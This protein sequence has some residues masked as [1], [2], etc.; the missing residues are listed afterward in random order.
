MKQVPLGMG[1]LNGWRVHLRDRI[2]AD[3]VGEAENLHDPELM[4]LDPAVGMTVSPIYFSIIHT[5]TGKHIGVAAAYN[6][7]G[8]EVEY[9]IRIWNRDFWDKGYGA[10]V[11]GLFCAWA[12]TM[13]IKAVILKTPE[14]NMRARKCYLNCGFEEFARG[15]IEGYDMIWMRKTNKEMQ[16]LWKYSTG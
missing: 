11:T 14:T 4:A 7:T 5:V 16:P 13:G 1:T 3:T 9:G 15:N 8:D 6:Y 10:E 12:F 2:Q